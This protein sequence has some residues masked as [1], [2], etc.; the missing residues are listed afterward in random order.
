MDTAMD[1]AMTTDK[2]VSFTSIILLFLAAKLH[3]LRRRIFNYF[4][5]LTKQEARRVRASCM[6]SAVWL[7][8]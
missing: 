3:R 8:F 7:V 1:A 5:E 4:L 6:V 2:P